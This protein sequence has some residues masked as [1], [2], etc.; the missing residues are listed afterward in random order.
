[1]NSFSVCLASLE[2]SL[3]IIFLR[4]ILPRFLNLRIFSRLR[5]RFSFLAFTRHASNSVVEV[6]LRVAKLD[7]G[8]KAYVDLMCGVR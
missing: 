2:A 8:A 7:A 6:I 1:M 5:T 3:R 4:E